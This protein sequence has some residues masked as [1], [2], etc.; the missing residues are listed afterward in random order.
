M[1]TAIDIKQ[2]SEILAAED[3]YTIQEK[4]CCCGQTFSYQLTESELGWLDFVRRK[5]SIADWIDEN[6]NGDILTFDCPE[7]MSKALDEDCENAGKAVCLSDDTAL[8]KLFFWLYSET[9][10]D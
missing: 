5:Y 2:S 9:E 7:N 8:Q 4:F 6:R 10:E 3:L 1:K